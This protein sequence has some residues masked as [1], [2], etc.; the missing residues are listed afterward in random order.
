MYYE[1]KIFFRVRLL[2]VVC[3]GV[4]EVRGWGIVRG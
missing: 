2:L 4:I 3:L 1:I